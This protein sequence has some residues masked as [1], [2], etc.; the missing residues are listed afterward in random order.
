MAEG[1]IEFTDDDP[2]PLLRALLAKDRGEA[3]DDAY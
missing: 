3:N 2:V 1:S